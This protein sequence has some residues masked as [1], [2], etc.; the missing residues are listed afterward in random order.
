MKN[1]QVSWDYQFYQPAGKK[2]VYKESVVKKEV[3]S[4]LENLKNRAWITN[5]EVKEKNIIIEQLLYFLF[6][7]HYQTV[8]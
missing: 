4:I 5:D 6:K 8:E 7:N 1:G 2:F 3:I